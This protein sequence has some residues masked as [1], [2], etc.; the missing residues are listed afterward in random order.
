MSKTQIPLNVKVALWAQAAGRCEYEGCNQRL[1]LDRVTSTFMYSGYIAHI[2]ADSADGPRG[3]AVRSP[4]LSKDLSNLMLACD[5]HHRLIDVERLEDHPA[6]RLFEMKRRHEQRIELL[7]SLLPERESHVLLYG[8]NIGNHSPVLSFQKAAQAMLPDWYPAESQAIEIGLKN[9]GVTDRNAAYWDL[10][11]ASLQ[12]NVTQFWRPRFAQGHIKH[13]SIF[14]LAPQPLLMKLGSLLSDIQA[15]R[16]YQLHREPVGWSWP[17][18]SNPLNFSLQTPDRIAGPPALVFSI[19]AT[20]IDER[21]ETTLPGASIW[22][23]SVPSPNNDVVRSPQDTAAF[24]FCLRSA[25]DRI[26]A[27]HGQSSVIHLFPAMPV[28]LAVD[29]GRVR[30]PK[31]DLPMIVYDE[32]RRAGGFRVALLLE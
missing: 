6:E 19:S 32:D 11:A 15:A 12:A 4:Q 7:T 13:L 22:K 20:V 10:E 30:M 9:S 27:A 5:V 24:R 28:S 2:V 29:T 23:I 18:E 16:T 17:S 8:A 31:A 25:L 21:V 3:D 1:F 14:A 26:K